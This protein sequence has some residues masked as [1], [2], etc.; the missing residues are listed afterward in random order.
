MMVSMMVASSTASVQS[1]RY[2]CT[3]ETSSE[4][5]TYTQTH[6]DNTKHID[7][8]DSIESE[9]PPPRKHQSVDHTYIHIEFSMDI[10]CSQQ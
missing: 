6:V 10:R 5:A 1:H 3:H 4:E 7:N 9:I 2:A 8:I